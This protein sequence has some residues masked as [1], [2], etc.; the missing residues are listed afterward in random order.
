MPNGSSDRVTSAPLQP[1]ASDKTLE[2]EEIKA[3]LAVSSGGC[4]GELAGW[5]LGG[6]GGGGLQRSEGRLAT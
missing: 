2:D 3:L 5:L 6:V 4:R 1:L